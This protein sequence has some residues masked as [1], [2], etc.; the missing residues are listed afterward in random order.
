[1][2]MTKTIELSHEDIIN[3]V[4]RW[5]IE[6]G[7]LVDKEDVDAVVTVQ[8]RPSMGQNGVYTAKCVAIARGQD[9]GRQK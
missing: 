7:F 8:V 9:Q 3:A 6:K 5:C 1:M 2:K 4:K